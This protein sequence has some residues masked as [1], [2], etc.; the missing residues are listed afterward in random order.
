MI[1]AAG[2]HRGQRLHRQRRGRVG[3]ERA[4]VAG[5]LVDMDARRGDQ[6]RRVRNGYYWLRLPII[7]QP[8]FRRDDLEIVDEVKIDKELYSLLCSCAELVKTVVVGDTSHKLINY[9]VYVRYSI[10]EANQISAWEHKNNPE[11]FELQQFLKLLAK[12][13][14]KIVY[15]RYNL[16]PVRKAGTCQSKDKEIEMFDPM[17]T[18]HLAICNLM[19]QGVS[20]LTIAQLAGDRR[21]ESQRTYESHMATYMQSKVA[22][23]AN[24]LT[25]FASGVNPGIPQPEF[26]RLEGRSKLFSKK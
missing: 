5:E 9:E 12:F 22:C 6:L 15:E 3:Q 19:F 23:L 16:V 25:I 1:P 18:R 2:G 4:Q 20:P 10:I 21:L 14:K 24:Q 7:K 11:E 13:Y 26:R 17:D 8:T